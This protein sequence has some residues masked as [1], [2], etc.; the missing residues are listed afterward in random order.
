MS[1]TSQ[2]VDGDESAQA[3]NQQGVEQAGVGP[4]DEPDPLK[5][6]TTFV[7]ILFGIAGAAVGLLMILMDAVDEPVLAADGGGLGGGAEL[8]SL[9]LLFQFPVLAVGLATF[10]GVGIAYKTEVGDDEVLRIAGAGPAAG[11]IVFLIVATFLA[12]TT[13][14]GASIAFGGLLINAIV[15]GIVA[16]IAGAGGAW[17][18][19]NK[20]PDLS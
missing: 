16:G 12:S 8:G 15:A 9:L 19:R 5:A 4:Q 3:E 13:F 14:A 6:W 1:E 2:Q 7:T 18:A 11:T 20:T 10:V 17:A